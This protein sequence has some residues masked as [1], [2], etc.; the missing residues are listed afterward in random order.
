MVVL[1]ILRKTGRTRKLSEQNTVAAKTMF[2]FL[3]A[4]EQ[5]RLFCRG[6]FDALT[7]NQWMRE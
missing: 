7:L 5:E 6:N 1:P 4:I 3:S 2:G